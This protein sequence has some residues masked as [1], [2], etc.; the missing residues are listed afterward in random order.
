MGRVGFAENSMWW[1]FSVEF[2]MSNYVELAFFFAWS[3][4]CFNLVDL[5]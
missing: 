2:V 4:Y 5:N 1:Y 3:R